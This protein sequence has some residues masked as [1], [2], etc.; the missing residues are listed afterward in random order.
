MDDFV[1]I[2]KLDFETFNV[3]IDRAKEILSKPKERLFTID[4]VSEL[5]KV[6]NQTAKTYIKNFNVPI[7]RISEKVIRYRESDI[8]EKIINKNLVKK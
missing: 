1:L 6:D 8:L 3:L 5:L 4:E 7:V 2:K